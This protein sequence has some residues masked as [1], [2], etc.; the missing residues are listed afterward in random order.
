MVAFA[1]V[2]PVQI[3]ATAATR[4][5]LQSALAPPPV[6]AHDQDAEA[7]ATGNRVF[8]GSPVEHCVEGAY[9]V[10]EAGKETP[11]AVPQTPGTATGPVWVAEQDA[12]APPFVPAHVH[13]AVAPATGNAVFEERPVAH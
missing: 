12:L 10:A 2:A 13:D 7:P 8:E 3:G 11:F 1:G 6:P 9:P 5:A 4:L